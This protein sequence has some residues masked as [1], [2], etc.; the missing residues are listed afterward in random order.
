M[1]TLH[2]HIANDGARIRTCVHVEDGAL[3]VTVGDSVEG[4]LGFDALTTVLERYGKPLADGMSLDGCPSLAL[5][6]LEPGARLCI[7]RHRALY[8]VIARDFVVLV[9]RDRE[10]FAELATMIA[11]AVTHIARATAKA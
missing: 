6:A 2:E 7:L 11:A 5:D 10:P 8:D 9:R 3:T 4:A 1:L